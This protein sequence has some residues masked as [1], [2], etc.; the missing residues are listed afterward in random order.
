[1][2]DIGYGGGVA[3]SG[4]AGVVVMEAG[5]R[6]FG[7]GAGRGEEGAGGGKNK[8]YYSSC[9]KIS[10]VTCPPRQGAEL[11]CSAMFLHLG[12]LACL[13]APQLKL[14]Q[15]GLIKEETIHYLHLQGLS[16]GRRVK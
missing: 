12:S 16:D 5:G 1:M 7:V 9:Q 10:S 11:R 8:K 15:L 3:E 13:S 6:D 14:W 2:A 4:C